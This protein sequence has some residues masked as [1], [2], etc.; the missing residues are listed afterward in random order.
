MRIL[1]AIR[2]D[3]TKIQN[4]IAKVNATL[5]P[6]DEL[7]ASLRWQLEQA[8]SGWDKLLASAADA[9]ANGESVELFITHDHAHK[10]DLAFGMAVATRGIEPMLKEILSESLKYANP[11]TVRMTASD[12]KR[13]LGELRVALYILSLEE[14]IAMT[15]SDAQRP[16]VHPGAV[17]GIPLEFIK[18][19][20]HYA[21]EV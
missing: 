16:G 19:S 11:N 18:D 15:P 20:H 6:Q 10:L 9:V 8:K 17:L 4:D 12:K 5:P 7:L 14:Q 13:E 3:I 2:K 1:H 21:F